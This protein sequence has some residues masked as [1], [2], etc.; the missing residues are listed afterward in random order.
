MKKMQCRIF[1]SMPDQVLSM[2]QWNKEEE[3]KMKIVLKVKPSR[4]KTKCSRWKLI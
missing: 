1:Y 2:N 3:E 4:D